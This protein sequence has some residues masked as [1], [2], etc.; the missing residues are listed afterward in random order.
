MD[1]EDDD[2]ADSEEMADIQAASPVSF[3]F[4]ANFQPFGKKS[5]ISGNLRIQQKKS[6]AKP[7]PKKV[8]EKKRKAEDSEKETPAKKAKADKKDK[9]SSYSSL[10]LVFTLKFRS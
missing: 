5:H 2:E 8:E 3:F 1:D 4:L 7:E 6:P 9:K 10:L